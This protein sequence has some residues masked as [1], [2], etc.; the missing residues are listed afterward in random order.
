M[1]DQAKAKEQFEHFDTDKNGQID[2]M[3]FRKLANAMGLGLES[4]DAEKCFDGIDVDE[5]GLVD[6]EEFSKWLAA[7]G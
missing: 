4:A 1:A 7:R 3:E 5:N 2:L 6:F